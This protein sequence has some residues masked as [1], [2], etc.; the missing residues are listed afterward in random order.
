MGAVSGKYLPIFLMI[1]TADPFQFLENFVRKNKLVLPK[2]F[3][4]WL[5]ITNTNQAQAAFAPG[6]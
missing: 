6:P 2:L 4:V 3:S 5:Y 1:F